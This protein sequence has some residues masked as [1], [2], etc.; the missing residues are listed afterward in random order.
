MKVIETI[1]NFCAT[2]QPVF[3]L[4]LL[5]YLIGLVKGGRDFLIKFNQSVDEERRKLEEQE[6]ANKKREA[7][8]IKF[9]QDM[10]KRSD[11]PNNDG[12]NT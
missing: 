4:I 11:Y 7:D 9:N 3:V 8:I 5:Y 6:A 1:S 2:I 12:N 10:L